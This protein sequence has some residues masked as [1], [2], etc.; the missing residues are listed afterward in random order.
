MG[1]WALQQ[2][3][4]RHMEQATPHAREGP[5]QRLPLLSGLSRAQSVLCTPRQLNSASPLQQSSLPTLKHTSGITEVQ[6]TPTL[7]GKLS[8]AQRRS[9]QTAWTMLRERQ[10][11]VLDG[12]ARIGSHDGLTR[13][14]S[15]AGAPT[16]TPLSIPKLKAT[17][18]ARMGQSPLAFPALSPGAAQPDLTPETRADRHA[19]HA[20]RLSRTSTTQETGKQEEAADRPSCTPLP[21]SSDAI[22]PAAF[23]GGVQTSREGVAAHDGH[24][25]GSPLLIEDTP[26]PSSHHGTRQLLAVPQALPTSA[27]IVPSLCT[28]HAQHAA[29]SQ[30]AQASA[31][32]HPADPATSGWAESLQRTGLDVQ[33]SDLLEEGSAKEPLNHAATAV[34]SLQG[35]PGG[36]CGNPPQPAGA[37]RRPAATRG[38]RRPR[39]AAAQQENAGVAH[40]QAGC[41]AAQR[42]P[43]LSMGT[44]VLGNASSWGK[45]GRARKRQRSE[46][47][48]ATK[49]GAG[50]LQGAEGAGLDGESVKARERRR[51]VTSMRGIEVT[52]EDRLEDGTRSSTGCLAASQDIAPAKQAAVLGLSS[53]G[54]A[55]SVLIHATLKMCVAPLSNCAGFPHNS[56]GYAMGDKESCVC[57]TTR[58]HHGVWL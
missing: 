51:P 18:A 26:Q 7:A 38:R 20:G 27:V 9:H 21:R 56:S 35:R 25:F 48:A 22:Y 36:E 16:P 49:P 55:L 28:Q 17:P 31:L 57:Q 8:T 43:L 34:Q 4:G 39:G 15:A 6:R 42:Q 30:R 41:Q 12:T 52:P 19:T 11:A 58:P 37:A 14:D 45:R 53:G 44:A 24:G 32:Q 40:Q 46:Q 10:L 3:Q 23:V 47:Q 13:A 2:Q 54:P 33:L 50:V 1:Q 29:A 5:C